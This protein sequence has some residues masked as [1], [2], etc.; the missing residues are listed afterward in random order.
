MQAP[1]RKWTGAAAALVILGL[2]LAGFLHRADPTGA[3]RFSGPTMGTTYRVTLA[4]DPGEAVRGELAAGIESTLVRI[5][6]RMST[7]DPESELSRFNAHAGT[8]WYPVSNETLGVIRAAQEISA[9][10]GGAFDITVGPL[11]DLWG[12][13]QPPELPPPDQRIADLLDRVGYGLLEVR[14]DPPAIRKRV[15]ELQVDLSA[16]AKGYAVDAIAGLLGDAGIS[17]YLVEIGGEIQAS[18]ANSAGQPWRIAIEKP[19]SEQRAAQRV[20]GLHDLGLATSGDYRN[21]FEVEGQRYSHTIDP[22][23]GRPVRHQVASVSVLDRSAMRADALATALLAMGTDGFAFATDHAIAA[24]VI[25][26]S[27][28]GQFRER[29]TPGFPA[30]PAGQE[31][32]GP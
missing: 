1:T 9:L 24:L 23:T 4:E 22:R 20:I 29:S 30:Q 12:F 2:L 19:L 32:S 13:V 10:T 8:D 18:G 6:G 28:D 31:Q 26:R 3:Y 27:A 15:P 11:V 17:D 5:N 16:I 21:Y 25:E 7:Y 14:D